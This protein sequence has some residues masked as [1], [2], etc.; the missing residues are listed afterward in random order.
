M[1]N[2][3]ENTLT[4]ESTNEKDLEIFKQK[5][6]G[7][8]TAL[9]LNNLVPLP[10]KQKQNWY[11]WRIANWGIKWNIKASI[12][13]ISNNKFEYYFDS[14]WSPPLAWLKKIAKM[15]PTITFTLE[16]EE[17]GMEFKGIAAVRGENF[18][19]DKLEYKYKDEDED[20]EVEYE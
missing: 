7:K 15:F 12:N 1:P 2:W 4:I 11:T 20:E 8:D 3:C 6:L 19:D 16:Y 9:S 10:K 17:P 14:A 18:I 5:S 13:K